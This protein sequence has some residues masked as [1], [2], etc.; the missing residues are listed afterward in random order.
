[1]RRGEIYRVHNPD[2]DPKLYRCFV[3][4][5]RQTLIDSKFP[6]VICAPILTRG[7]GFSTQVLIGIDEGLKH[8]SWIFCDNLVSLRKMQLTRFIGSLTH[9]KQEEIDRALKMA[10]ALE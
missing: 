10:L 9:D 7:H 2:D 3:V 1:M 6:T 4:V 8:E 5:S